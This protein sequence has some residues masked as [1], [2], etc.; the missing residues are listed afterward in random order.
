[1]SIQIQLNSEWAF[2]Y[3]PAEELNTAI[4]AL[5]YDDSGWNPIG[6]PHTW[7]TYETTGECHPFI[8]NP[9]ER[10]STFWWYG[11]GW[12]R[13]TIIVQPVHQDKLISLEFDGVQKA[14]MVYVNGVLAGE[15]YGGFTS[16]SVDVDAYIR[17]DGTKNVIAVAV[18]N[19]RNDKFGGIPPV[20]AGNWN[21]YGGIYRDVRLAV[22]NP[23]HIPYQGSWEHEGGTRITTPSVSR[24]RANVKVHTYVRNGGESVAQCTLRT[25]LFDPNGKPLETLET[26]KT[27]AP[28]ETALLEQESD[29]IQEPLLWSPDSPW[30]YQV[31]SEVWHDDQLTDTMYSPLGFR[32]FHWDYEEKRLWLN[33]ERIHLHGTNRHQEYPWL[34]DAIPKWLHAQDL[35]DIKYGLGHNFLRTCHYTQDKMV[36]DWCDRHGLIVCEEVPN[37]KNIDFNEEMQERQVREMIR[38]DRNHPSILMWSMGN[39]TNKA[40]DARWAREEDSTRIVHYRHVSGQ[41]SDE[42]HNDKQMDMENVLRCTVRGWW[43]ADMMPLEPENGQH[44]GHEKWQHDQALVEGGSQR[45]RIDTNGAM[46]VYADHGCDREYVN[47]PLLHVNPKGWVDAYREPKL[48]YYVWKAFWTKEPFLYVHPYD[49]TERYLGTKR[50]IT[51]NTNCHAV[52]LLVDGESQ[53]MAHANKD[54]VAIF[55]DVPVTGGVLAAIGFTAEGAEAARCLVPMPGKPHQLV[56]QASHS[57]IKAD[58]SDVV[59][60][61]IDAVDTEGHHVYGAC[62]DLVIEVSGP[63]KL[64]CPSVLRSDLKSKEARE[65][66]FYMDLPITVPIRST[67]EPGMIEVSVTY[68]GRMSATLT[69]PSVKPAANDEYYGV[70]QPD[71]ACIPGPPLRDPSAL[72]NVEPARGTLNLYVD[73]LHFGPA[74][75]EQYAALMDL[76]LRKHNPGSISAGPA[77]EAL[78]EQL[79]EALVKDH[80]TLVADDYNFIVTKY[81][82]CCSVYEWLEHSALRAAIIEEQKSLYADLLIRRGVRQ[83]LQ[84]I[85]KKVIKLELGL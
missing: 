26:S 44:C 10:D 24:E 79:V 22:K 82:D 36:Y 3:E 21:V 27:L 29:W 74:E 59:L 64:L 8:M 47:S 56:L 38:R 34:G 1:M 53:G 77:Y 49:W 19:R 30:L 72:G 73:D 17:K 54:R 13:K 52:Q 42:P 14:A 60:V 75:A 6:L 62:G 80:G 16:F 2:R 58:R 50:Q 9:S 71:A 48:M 63:G 15:H 85:K 46:W 4:A 18:S 57:V 51:V 78:I 25:T 20:T 39:E 67:K 7:S 41:G 70:I 43:N 69:L 5:D 35:H 83:D 28:Y 68:E 81:N 33:G 31:K 55:H 12:Y 32:W 65:G 23:V 66:T 61:R 84:E 37:I 11:W 45:G 40:A 76:H